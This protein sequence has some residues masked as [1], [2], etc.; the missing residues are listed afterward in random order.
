MDV[1]SRDIGQQEIEK[2]LDYKKISH[3]K[4]EIQKDHIDSL[5]DAIC[6]GSI[7]LK[8][9]FTIVHNLK[10]PTDGEL[11]VKTLEYKPRLKMET[12]HMHLQGVKSQDADGRLCA[13]VAALTSKPKDLVRKLDT[14]DY[15]IA[16]SIAIFF[17]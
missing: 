8:D 4:R 2:W 10:F 3:K 14:E 15:T 7:S 9:D 6:D 16:Q 12:I 1:I 17:L 5:V 13:H 11:P